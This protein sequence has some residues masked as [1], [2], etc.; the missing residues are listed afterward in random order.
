VKGSQIRERIQK[1]R[2]RIPGIALRSTALV[3]YPGETEAEFEELC[4]F[5]E[6]CRFDHLGI[7]AYSHEE[8]TASYDLPEQL[9][10]ATKKRRQETLAA[11]QAKISAD[12]LKSKVGKEL[13]V[14]VEEISE[15]SEF[16]WRGRYEGQAPDIDGHILI[17]GGE[18]TRGKIHKVKIE[19]TMEYDLIGRVV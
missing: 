18:F 9:D 16:L 17:R 19:R 6:E 12:I 4:R 15:E 10:E 5:V 8:G 11:L 1:I 2:S 13:L 14:L 3:G 7:F